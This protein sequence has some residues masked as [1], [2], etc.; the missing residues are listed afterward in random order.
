MYT[1]SDDLTVYR[2]SFGAQWTEIQK[3]RPCYS[4]TYRHDEVTADW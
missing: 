4:A 1:C 2:N 3:Q